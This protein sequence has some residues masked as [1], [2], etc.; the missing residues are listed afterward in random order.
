MIVYRLMIS[1]PLFG[2][3]FFMKKEV[4]ND[5]GQ[6]RISVPLFGDSFFILSL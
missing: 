1:V 5:E 4:R 6:Q 2:D 3:S